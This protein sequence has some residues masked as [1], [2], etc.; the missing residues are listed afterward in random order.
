MP[1]STSGT[2][3][4]SRSHHHGLTRTASGTTSTARTMTAHSALVRMD[5]IMSV[6]PC[7]DGN[8]GPAGPDWVRSVEDVP[9]L[10][11]L[12]GTRGRRQ[13]RDVVAGEEPLEVVAALD[14]LGDEQGVRRALGEDLLEVRVVL[15][16]AD[17]VGQERRAHVGEL[18]DD[19][20]DV[21]LVGDVAVDDGHRQVVHAPAEVAHEVLGGHRQVVEGV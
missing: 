16:L 13:R 2:K 1:S 15:A 12:V 17:D 14:V 18:A 20:V 7:W 3:M 10:V 9:V 4:I 19:V 21:L 8:V 5:S 6:S 11:A